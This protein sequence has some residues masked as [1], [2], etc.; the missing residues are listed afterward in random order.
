MNLLLSIVIPAFNEEKKIECD[1]AI[2]YEYLAQQ[3]YNYEVLVVDD[4][5]KDKTYEIV[6]SLEPRYE[7]LRGI[8]YEKNRG[9][10]YAVKTGMLQ[11]KG[12]YVL[13]S[14]A[15]TCVPYQDVE[16][17]LFLLQNGYDVALGSRALE[18]SNVLQKQPKYRQI[19]SQV[20]GFIVRFVMGVNPIQDTQCGFKL[21]KKNAAKSIFIKNQI[22]GF[23]FDTETI[24]NAKKMGFKLKEFP[25]TWMNDPDTRYDPFWGSIRN[26]VELAK[27][28]IS[29]FI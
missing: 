12:E 5:S 7:N 19:G 6:K 24:L 14:D 22:N 25:V 29:R 15:G 10:G 3:S 13:F 4:G 23:M 18:G 21:F 8:R 17:G 27:I 28:K 20:F 1:L 16:K 9:K 11:A 2:V 26:F